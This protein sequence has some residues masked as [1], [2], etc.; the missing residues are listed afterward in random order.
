MESEEGKVEANNVGELDQGGRVTLREWEERIE[1]SNEK[2]AK[3]K[4]KSQEKKENEK[5]KSEETKE[6]GI[7]KSEEKNE[8]EKVTPPGK[9]SA[10]NYPPPKKSPASNYPTG[11]RENIE[12]AFAERLQELAAVMAMGARKSGGRGGVEEEKQEEEEQEKE[13]QEQGW[14]VPDG[15]FH[16][17]EKGKKREADCMEKTLNNWVIYQR[18]AT[19]VIGAKSTVIKSKERIAKDNLEGR[20]LRLEGRGRKESKGDATRAEKKFSEMKFGVSKPNHDMKLSKEK[21]QNNC[22]PRQAS[23]RA[24]ASIIGLPKMSDDGVVPAFQTRTTNSSTSQNP[25]LR[26]LTRTEKAR[27][28]CS[29]EGGNRPQPKVISKLWLLSRTKLSQSSSVMMLVKHNHCEHN[30]DTQPHS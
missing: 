20:I 29:S 28:V 4:E 6:K 12:T 26:F 13:K 22:S 27:S 23:L 7:V 2:K 5:V 25:A 24:K 21:L 17:D 14:A 15:S 11:K 3:G 19:L 30:K 16:A 18:V 1:K 8:K 10:G 9:T